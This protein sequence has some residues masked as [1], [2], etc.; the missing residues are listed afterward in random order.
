VRKFNSFLNHYKFSKIL[1]VGTGNGN[2]IK[3]IVSMTDSFEEIIGID[4][5]EIAVSASSKN[6]DDE[7]ISFQLMDGYKMDF[8]DDSFDLVCLSN[9]LHHLDDIKGLFREME[10]VLKP[11]GFILLNEMMANGLSKKQKTHMKIHH[12]AASIDR[13]NG[14]VHNETMKAVDILKTLQENS[15]LT[16]KDAWNLEV[17]RPSN[18]TKEEIDWLCSTVDRIVEKVQDHQDYHSFV[19]EGEKIKKYIKKVGFDSAT[20]LMVILS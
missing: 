17:D 19:K 15:E 4:E 9:T 16:I 1:D 5:M 3:L 7:R 10:R 20:Q 13:I 12:F 2:F 14:D 6:F 8:D 18:N 11:G